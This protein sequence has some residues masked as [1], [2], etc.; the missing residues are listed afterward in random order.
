M[1]RQSLMWRV[2]AT[3]SSSVVGSVV[4]DKDRVRSGLGE[5]QGHL[6]EGD[7][8]C[9]PSLNEWCPPAVPSTRSLE[10]FLAIL[11]RSLPPPPP[12]S[13]PVRETCIMEQKAAKLCSTRNHVDEPPKRG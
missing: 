8:R 4:R 3:F 5:D 12:P 10:T 6:L 7:E 13:P 11:A 1:P 2:K 9:S